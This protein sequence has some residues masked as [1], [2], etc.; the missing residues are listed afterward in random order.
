M[1]DPE[2]PLDDLRPRFLRRTL[3]HSPAI[4]WSR[5]TSNC[6]A[7]SIARAFERAE[8]TSPAGTET[9]PRPI[10]RMPNVK[11]DEADQQDAERED[12]SADGDRIDVAVADGRQR[13][14]GPPEAVEDRSELLRLCFTLEMMDADRRQKEQDG[15]DAEKQDD[16]LA[17]DRQGAMK[18]PHRLAVASE[19]QDAEEPKESERA[20]RSQVDPQRQ[21][22]RQDR[23][24]IDQP[25]EAEDERQ[26]PFRRTPV[27]VPPPGPAARTRA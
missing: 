18:S 9:T 3:R 7:S 1:I 2:S 13:R 23:E 14:D 16:L 6:S 8:A 17:G 4:A 12:A 15:G 10:S 5:S 26:F 22:E 11:M 21:I 27:S 24:Q 25:E 19:L 20:H